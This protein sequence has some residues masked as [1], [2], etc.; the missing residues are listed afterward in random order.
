MQ[1]YELI[2]QLALIL[3][4]LLSQNTEA[5]QINDNGQFSSTYIRKGTSETVNFD[6]K[7]SLMTI[8]DEADKSIRKFATR[9]CDPSS[10]YL[11]FKNQELQFAVPRELKGQQR[12]VHDGMTYCVVFDMK[13]RNSLEYFPD[14][15]NLAIGDDID[16][17]NIPEVINKASYE[18]NRG[19][20]SLHFGNY[21]LTSLDSL[22][23]GNYI[24]QH[25]TT[26]LTTKDS[27]PLDCSE[28]NMV[29]SHLRTAF[30]S[31]TQYYQF[32]GTETT[33]K[34]RHTGPASHIMITPSLMAIQFNIDNRP[35]R[36]FLL[37]LKVK[38]GDVDYQ[39]L[40]LGELDAI[41][42][43]IHIGKVVQGKCELVFNVED[44]AIYIGS[45]SDYDYVKSVSSGGDVLENRFIKQ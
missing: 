39:L 2:S 14:I 13:S 45:A 35:S 12:W 43:P 24:S 36:A 26:N 20:S 29:W 1:R 27:V 7:Q 34:A 28:D 11:C 38:E 17:N 31:K 4:L 6:P 44:G 30:S 3:S 8:N 41:S 19:L 15:L 40:F 42:N 23:F 10:D 37:G 16:C 25:L 22:G 9:F 5:A 33:F 21:N 18:N 32:N